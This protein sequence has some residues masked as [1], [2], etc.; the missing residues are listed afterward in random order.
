MNNELIPQT[1]ILSMCSLIYCM[2][3]YIK[4]QSS[5]GHTAALVIFSFTF[6]TINTHTNTHTVV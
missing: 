6:L 5:V 3:L 2:L 1:G 4:M